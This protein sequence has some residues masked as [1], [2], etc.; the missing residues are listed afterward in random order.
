MLI[1]T[2]ARFLTFLCALIIDPHVHHR[3]GVVSHNFPVPSV[4]F[5][6]C[7]D[8]VASLVGPPQLVPCSQGNGFVE[9]P[10]TTALILSDVGLG[11]NQQLHS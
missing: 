3:G 4:F 9:Y 11:E 8:L 7:S 1:P 6:T 2:L 10:S 5:V